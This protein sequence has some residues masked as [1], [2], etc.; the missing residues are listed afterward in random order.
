VEEEVSGGG[1]VW[2]GGCLGRIR[3]KMNDS[4]KI[5]VRV[6]G[7]CV[8]LNSYSCRQGSVEASCDISNE[9]FGSV[10]YQEIA[11][12]QLDGISQ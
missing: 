11:E 2:G 10:K 1:G 9:T 12:K 7:H 8:G 6:V 3:L 5:N 4:D